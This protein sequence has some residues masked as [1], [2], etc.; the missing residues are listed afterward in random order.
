[1]TL[2]INIPNGTSEELVETQATNPFEIFDKQVSE[3]RE[4]ME[5]NLRGSGLTAGDFERIKIPAGGGT[6]WTIQGLQGE[7][8]VK[9][10]DCV[11]LTWRDRRVYWRLPMEQSE[12]NLPP[13][14]YSFDGG[15]GVGDPGGD[16]K[17]C[18]HAA[19]GSGAKGEAPAC[20]LVRQL[21]LLRPHDLLPEVVNLP[22]SSHKP[23]REYLRRLASKGVPCYGVI[24]RLTLEK[25]K[26]AQGIV[27]SK[28]VLTCAGRLTQGQ[29]QQVKEYTA[30]IEPFLMAA[31]AV[32]PAND[33]AEPGDGEIV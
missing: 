30:M 3:I 14:C 19:F 27:Y 24:T 33:V 2:N 15:R 20:R 21:F 4:A 25:V 26:N 28:A 9:E 13:D 6:V 16:C 22:P 17:K 18:Q 32:P 23:A 10:L 12:G 1:M 31:P 29:T 5:A 8:M 7:E 11:L